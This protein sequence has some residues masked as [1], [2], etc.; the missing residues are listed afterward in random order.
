MKIF[1]KLIA[2]LSYFL[3]SFFRHRADRRATTPYGR[4]K[5]AAFFTTVDNIEN[6][7]SY[8]MCP[9]LLEREPQGNIT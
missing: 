2:C 1:F 6:N 5:C 3:S 8:N 7:K 9:G 4:W